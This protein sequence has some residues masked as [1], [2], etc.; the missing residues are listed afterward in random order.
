VSNQSA[1]GIQCDLVAPYTVFRVRVE[2]LQLQK[3][4]RSETR[5]PRYA[6]RQ[7]ADRAGGSTVASREHP[8]CRVADYLLICGSG[9]TKASAE[10]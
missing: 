10:T 2:G 3:N 8:Q 5:F 9:I 6:E 1:K 7:A 4:G